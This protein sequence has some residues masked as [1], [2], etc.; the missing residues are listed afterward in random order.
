MFWIEFQADC[1]SA[2]AWAITESRTPEVY[3]HPKWGI[4]GWEGE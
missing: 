4:M 1:R 3:F 2:E